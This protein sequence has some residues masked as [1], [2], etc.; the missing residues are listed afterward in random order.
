MAELN[1]QIKQKNGTE[2][3]SL[4]PKT[5]ATVVTMP[6]GTTTLDTALNGK[7]D[8]VS[9]KQLSTND[10]TTPLK[11]KLESLNG[12]TVSA[13]NTPPSDGIWLEII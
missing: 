6:D 10:F 7:V 5:K 13:T 1:I 12:V 9:G 8:K 3:D 2:W 4:Y 11:T